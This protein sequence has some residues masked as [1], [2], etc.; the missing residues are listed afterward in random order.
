[1]YPQMEDIER[2][3]QE[4]IQRND[5]FS[6]LLTAIDRAV[7]ENAEVVAYARIN[8]EKPNWVLCVNPKLF[9]EIVAKTGANERDFLYA[10][11]LH[12][13]F[14]ISREH[15]E[16]ARPLSE[17]YSMREINIAADLAI[18]CTLPE[19]SQSV[20]GQCGG[21]FPSQFG[22]GDGLSLE[23]YLGSFRDKMKNDGRFYKNQTSQN[24]RSWSGDSRDQDH[25]K[26]GQ[27]LSE[28]EPSLIP[29]PDIITSL[30][31]Q[32]RLIQ[33]QERK[34]SEGGS[35]PQPGEDTASFSMDAAA[36]LATSVLKNDLQK[37]IKHYESIGIPIRSLG[38][39]S[40]S[41]GFGWL[42]DWIFP[43]V[44]LSWKRLLKNTLMGNVRSREWYRSFRRNHPRADSGVLLKGKYPY[45]KEKVLVLLDTS[46]S[47]G[48]GDYQ[49]FFGVLQ[50]LKKDE[51]CVFIA[52]WD[53][54]ALHQEPIPMETYLKGK[55]ASFRGG[56]G[57]DMMAGVLH[58]HEKYPDFRRVIVVTDG[59]TR[60]FTKENPSPVPLI[61]VLTRYCEFANAD[62]TVINLQ[63]K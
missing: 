30:K 4:G 38:I 29:V 21:I 49:Q 56:G 39:G 11:L 33:E 43:K 13:F 52:Q 14:H 48:S 57:T 8:P 54:G 20:I 61:W 16:R 2:L 41:G 55:Q 28:C 22:F 62:G 27:P 32:E 51:M 63:A 15:F 42:L 3:I 37:L 9:H 12:E 47:M 25:Q 19:R 35:Q 5:F 34:E 60:Y 45:K 40:G 59:G 1:M 58:I 31:E 53:W 23:Q 18:N 36:G 46:G 17:Y 10:L 6:Y 24:I 44:N 26:N 50:S 7:D